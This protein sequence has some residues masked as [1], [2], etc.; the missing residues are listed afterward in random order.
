MAR[1]ASP[2]EINGNR[3]LWFKPYCRACGLLFDSYKEFISHCEEKHWK[4]ARTP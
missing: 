3:K 1:K 2:Q 4:E